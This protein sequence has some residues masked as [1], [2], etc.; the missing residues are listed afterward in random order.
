MNSEEKNA[1]FCDALLGELSAERRAQLDALLQDPEA[2]AEYEA[3][4]SMW[5]DLGNVLAAPASEDASALGTI[6]R[7][8]PRRASSPSRR[9][10][11]GALAAGVA[12]FLLG[13]WVGRTQRVVE[14][15]AT[16]PTAAGQPHRAEEASGADV[17]TLPRFA[18]L[19]YGRASG[20]PPD[21]ARLQQVV[22]EMTAWRD[23]LDAERRHIVAEKLSAQA[24]VELEGVGGTVQQRS[25]ASSSESLRLGGLYI[26]HASDLDEATSIARQCPLL[27]Y[28]GVVRVRAIDDV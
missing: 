9:W 22:D 7:E 26:I 21:A 5:S 8:L 27:R 10:W 3:L 14:P 16:E 15:R 23:Q 19:L 24:G 4:Q 2:R 25:A 1:L 6:V 13:S 12:L 28:G 17:V 11:A 20:A 18:V